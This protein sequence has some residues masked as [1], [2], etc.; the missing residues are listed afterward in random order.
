MQNINNLIDQVPGSS[1]EI[2]FEL[3]NQSWNLQK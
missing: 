2:Q 3:I 1:L